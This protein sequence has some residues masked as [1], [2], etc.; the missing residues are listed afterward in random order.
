M[1]SDEGWSEDH[2]TITMTCRICQ[3]IYTTPVLSDGNHSV[4]CPVGHMS[5]TQQR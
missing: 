2:M 5:T 1:A 3:S 4:L